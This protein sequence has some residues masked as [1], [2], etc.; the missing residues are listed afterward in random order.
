MLATHGQGKGHGSKS[1]HWQCKWGQIKVV[2]MRCNYLM[3][4]NPKLILYLSWGS[5]VS[6]SVHLLL[7]SL[8][9]YS[10]T[11]GQNKRQRK[12]PKRIRRQWKGYIEIHCSPDQVPVINPNSLVRA[13]TIS[14]SSKP[15][16][17]SLAR[18]RGNSAAHN[19]TCQTRKEQSQKEG[20]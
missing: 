17:E 8:Y 12:N 13:I 19:S 7:L 1:I 15:E 5:P 20:Q 18:E 16:E 4:D 14:I 10:C 9:K 2:F 6:S 3:D 11:E